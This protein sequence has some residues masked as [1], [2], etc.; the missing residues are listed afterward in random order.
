M[1]IE[2]K[3][4]ITLDASG[5]RDDIDQLAKKL[6]ALSSSTNTSARS[7]NQHA[8]ATG[9]LNDKV[10]RANRSLNAMRGIMVKIASAA[11]IITGIRLA[12]DYNELQN[13]LRLT[14]QAGENL[15]DTE[16]K[17]LAV[18]L[19][20]RSS[21]KENALLYLR[22]SS[23]VDRAKVSQ[24]ELFQITETVNKAVQLGGSSAQEAA[25]AVR[26]FT[27][28]ISAGFTSGFSQ[29]INSIA[30]QTPGLFKIMSQGLRE[31]STEF[32]RLEESGLSSIKILKIFSE[33]G[34][35]DLD[36]LLTAI[37]SQ[38]EAANAAFENVN[39][40]VS[41]AMGNVKTSLEA[42]VG[43]IDDAYDIT[44]KLAVQIDDIAKNFNQYANQLAAVIAP[45][46]LF[47]ATYQAASITMRVFNAVLFTTKSSMKG[48]GVMLLAITSP[49]ALVAGAIAGLAAI[50]FG[51]LVKDIATFEDGI[52]RV[53]NKTTTFFGLLKSVAT[54]SWDY[55]KVLIGNI[56]TGFNNAFNQTG[57]VVSNLYNSYIKPF[58]NSMVN[59]FNFVKD[60][61]SNAFTQLTKTEWLTSFLSTTKNI[62]N[63]LIGF[64]IVAGKS[65]F[66]IFKNLFTTLKASFLG[67]VDVIKD[68]PSVIKALL[69]GDFEGAGIILAN[70]LAQGFKDVDLV[71]N[72]MK[73]LDGVKDNIAET[74]FIGAVADAATASYEQVS[75]FVMSI[76]DLFAE[77]LDAV[78]A[79][80]E[81]FK[82]KVKDG[83][84]PIVPTAD[85]KI[86][87]PSQE[88]RAERD[89]TLAQKLTQELAVSQLLLEKQ[90]SKTGMELTT[91]FYNIGEN[92]NFEVISVRL[93]TVL[94]DLKADL[95][96][97]FSPSFWTDNFAQIVDAFS[98]AF[99]GITTLFSTLSD[100]RQ[101]KLDEELRTSTTLSDEE[102]A[103]KE[104]NAKKSFETS[105]KLTLA[106]ISLSTG[107]AVMGAL[108]DGVNVPN[109]FV[110]LA[111][112]TGAAAMGASQYAKANAQ[113]YSAP[114]APSGA[115]MA[116]SAG[117][118]VSNNTSS[119]TININAGNS[120]PAAI[121]S[122]LQ[123]Y[124][125]D[126]D[127][128]II[129]PDSS[130]G[131]LLNA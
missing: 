56:L 58:A 33:K 76:P 99:M 34:L 52:V 118:N 59:A 89:M 35:G 30:E 11:T 1:G 47:I 17:L 12:D 121:A 69:T 4:K 62:I 27:Q 110:R 109:F 64:F 60:A 21:L 44:G 74:D 41:K 106:G 68:I 37:T 116:S 46:L 80:Y 7:T 25:G 85:V 92:A 26:Q 6:S 13:K 94:T 83:I 18:S 51:F 131:R 31:T 28:I 96:E 72:I 61:I 84:E 45:T 87:Y 130:Q 101:Q 70:G 88:L 43:G 32:Q 79:A 103:T 67:L 16:Q 100:I 8:T 19:K 115:S 129:N 15:Y 95:V 81:K 123:S 125:N 14:V 86:P 91:L 2:K 22:L 126:N 40:T 71:G 119:T 39:V 122:A 53:G 128:I 9:K 36:M 124:I 107:L 54:V 65:I 104:A 50:S 49:I 75:D 48:L 98:N 23:A 77:G 10:I 5:A 78:I 111:N 20:T 108:A 93:K 29:E 105:K 57:L 90:I 38:S 102:R 114:S 73:D 55:F 117:G 63:K 97:V 24:D 127:G 113:T 82:D 112:A 120:S 66:I 42:Y 3:I